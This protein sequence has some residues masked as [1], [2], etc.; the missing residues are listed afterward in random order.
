MSTLAVT[1]T[2]ATFFVPIGMAG[3][4]LAII[5]AVVATVAIARGAAG[6]T[7]GAIGVWI[8]GALLSMAAS[9]AAQW[10]PLFAALIAL[11]VGIALGGVIRMLVLTTRAKPVTASIEMPLQEVRVE[12]PQVASTAAVRT[13]SSSVKASGAPATA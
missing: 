2:L 1:N 9:F 12:K 4:A 13:Q 7:G 5:C 3:A 6:L 10:M 8:V 11:A